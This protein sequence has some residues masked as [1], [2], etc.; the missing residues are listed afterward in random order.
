MFRDLLE[1]FW[2]VIRTSSKIENEK[3]DNCIE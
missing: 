2:L 1:D 3:T